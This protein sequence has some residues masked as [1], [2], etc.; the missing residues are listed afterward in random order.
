MLNLL[1]VASV[2]CRSMEKMQVLSQNRDV[3]GPLEGVRP[4]ITCHLPPLLS[5]FTSL[6]EALLP[7]LTV[8]VVR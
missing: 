7:L 2:Q 5:P 8:S 6:T 1:E 4:P 3:A